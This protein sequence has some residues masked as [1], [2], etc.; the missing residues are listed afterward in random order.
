MPI[1]K[2][3]I[4][5]NKYYYPKLPGTYLYVCPLDKLLFLFEMPR[6]R[7]ERDVSQNEIHQQYELQPD[8]GFLQVLHNAVYHQCQY[9]Q[10]DQLS[11]PKRW[12]CPILSKNWLP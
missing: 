11:T 12:N 4:L 1:V 9:I 2:H 7:Q 5:K 8:I 6:H 10:G 3:R